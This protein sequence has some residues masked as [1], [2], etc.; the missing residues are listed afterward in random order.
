MV[1]EVPDIQSA[2]QKI[3]TD[4]V[5]AV[6]YEVNGLKIRGQ[7]VIFGYVEMIKAT[8]LMRHKVAFDNRKLAKTLGEAGFVGKV[9]Q[10]PDQYALLARV[11]KPVSGL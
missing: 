2:A 3:V 1:I 7:D 8:D 9:E 5:D 4:G 6:L 10:Y 11:Q